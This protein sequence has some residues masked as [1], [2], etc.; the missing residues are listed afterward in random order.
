M[1]LLAIESS[2]GYITKGNIYEGE[3][4]YIPPEGNSRN[5]TY[6]FSFFCDKGYWTEFSRSYFAPADTAIV[7]EKERAD[8][9]SAEARIVSLTF[10]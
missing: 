1:K 4:V 2:E 3:I 8:R 7:P 9:A 10:R 6:K 5:G